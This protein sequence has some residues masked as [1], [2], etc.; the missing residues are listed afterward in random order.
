MLIPKESLRW[1]PSIIRPR[2]VL[3]LHCSFNMVLGPIMGFLPN[4]VRSLK[5]VSLELC[6]FVSSCVW[7]VL[8]YCMDFPQ[9]CTT[10]QTWPLPSTSTDPPGLRLMSATSCGASSA[11]NGRRWADR[12]PTDVVCNFLFACFVLC[13]KLILFLR[14]KNLRPGSGYSCHFWVLNYGVVSEEVSRCRCRAV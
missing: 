9:Q 7:R 11:L 4:P 10:E 6:G 1:L 5:L 2:V 13:T 3:T 12:I 8:W 14:I